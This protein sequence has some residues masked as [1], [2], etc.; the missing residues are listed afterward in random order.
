[1]T[2]ISVAFIFLD[3]DISNIS[4]GRLVGVYI[5]INRLPVQTYILLMFFMFTTV[6]TE[7]CIAYNDQCSCCHISCLGAAL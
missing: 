6:M 1:V 3:D 7:T 5:S 4:I 2:I